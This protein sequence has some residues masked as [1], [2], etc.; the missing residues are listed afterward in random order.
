[1]GFPGHD[2]GMIGHDHR[3]THIATVDTYIRW[4]NEA[5]IEVSLGFRSPIEQRKD[6]GFPA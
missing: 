1:M 5:L 2:P 4:Y 6:L 3:N